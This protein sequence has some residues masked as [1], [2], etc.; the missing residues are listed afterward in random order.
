[1]LSFVSDVDVFESKNGD[2]K[3]IVECVNWSI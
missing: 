2:W 3:G 1:M